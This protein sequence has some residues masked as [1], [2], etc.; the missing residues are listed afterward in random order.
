M[1]KR[2][3]M[4]CGFAV[5][6]VRQSRTVLAAELGPPRK[7]IDL[8]QKED[9]NT[10]WKKTVPILGVGGPI[11]DG[12]GPGTDFLAEFCWFKRSSHI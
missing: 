10:N 3:G 9:R 4:H 7:G 1:K 2:G 12:N 6:T 5:G 11:P 8:E